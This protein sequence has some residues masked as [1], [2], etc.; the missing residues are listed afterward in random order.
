MGNG[1]RL[2]VLL[3]LVMAAIAF[4]A[5]SPFAAALPDPVDAKQQVAAGGTAPANDAKKDPNAPKPVLSAKELRRVL[6][7]PTDKLKTGID[8]GTPLKDAL[9]FIF[10]T[11]TVRPGEAI[12]YRIETRAFA[13]AGEPNI[14]EKQVELPPMPAVPLSVILNDLLS[15]IDPPEAQGTCR[16]MNGYVEITTLER[17]RSG[18]ILSL[19]IDI[20]FEK[21]P[22]EEALQEVV[23]KNG[24]TVVLDGAAGE[25][26]KTSITAVFQQVPLETIVR[27]IADMADLRVVP[28]E[29]IL[30]VTTKEKAETLRKEKKRWDKDKEQREQKNRGGAGA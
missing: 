6:A 4:V 20:E 25:R 22:L 13:D 27:L 24:V 16:V 2:S 17:V 5:G 9:D 21:R 28:V 30:Y 23:D 11:H 12:P 14:Y 3:I 15:R 29:N 19:P 10:R 8:K 7:E 26:A 1:I 18:M